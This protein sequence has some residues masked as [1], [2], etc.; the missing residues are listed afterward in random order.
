LRPPPSKKGGLAAQEKGTLFAVSGFLALLHIEGDQIPSRGLFLRHRRCK[1]F[2]AQRTG[3]QPLRLDAQGGP[4]ICHHTGRS[5]RNRGPKGGPR[6]VHRAKFLP[7]SLPSGR[8]PI[9]GA[10]RVINRGNNRQTTPFMA[11]AHPGASRPRGPG[12]GGGKPALG[13]A[14]KGPLAPPQT[15]ACLAAASIPGQGPKAGAFSRHPQNGRPVVR[16]ANRRGKRNGPWPCT[17]AFAPHRPIFPFPNTRLAARGFF[18]GRG[19]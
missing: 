9:E 15:L 12:S 3:V 18:S 19:W 7:P 1:K 13:Q 11:V 16:F 5:H 8:G 17:E 2:S 6:A 4:S 10:V 14:G